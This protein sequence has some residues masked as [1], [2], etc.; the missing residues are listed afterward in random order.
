MSLDCLTYAE[1][2]YFNLQPL[3]RQD[4][5]SILRERKQPLKLASLDEFSPGV[6]G[7]IN[8]MSHLKGAAHSIKSRRR[9]KWRYVRRKK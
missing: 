8:M 3:Y 2:A 1:E 5:M 6:T 9:G 4:I 7:F